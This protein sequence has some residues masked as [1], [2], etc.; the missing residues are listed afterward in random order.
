MRLL[1]AIFLGSVLPG[2]VLG[3]SGANLYGKLPLSFERASDTEFIARGRGYAVDL[4]GARASIAVPGSAPVRVEFVHG[5]RSNAFPEK[6]LPGK[7]N[8]ILGNDPRRWRVGLPTYERVKYC[9]LYPGIDVAYYGN[10][11]QLEFDLM[12]QPG[13]DLNSVRMRFSGAG[14]VHTDA[15][16]SLVLGDLRLNVPT[17]LQGDRRIDV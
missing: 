11:R 9:D 3:Q 4:L 5:R 10:Q 16:G 15:S 12:L 14:S 8:Y 7:V 13:A 1:F 17:V 6:G 2:C